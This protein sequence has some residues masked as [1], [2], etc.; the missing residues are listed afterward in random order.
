MSDLTPA[1]LQEMEQHLLSYFST[2]QEYQSIVKENNKKIANIKKEIKKYMTQ[3]NLTE[4][5]LAGRTFSFEKKESVV[6]S[7][8]RIEKSFDG[9]AVKK[10]KKDNYDEKIVFKVD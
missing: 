2:Q 8:D 7:M 6:L 9:E 3:H 1:M 10:Y 4:Y 5:T